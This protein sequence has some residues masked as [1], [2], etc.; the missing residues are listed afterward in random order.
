MVS[1]TSYTYPTETENDNSQFQSQG[2]SQ[3][4]RDSIEGNIKA[5]DAMAQSGLLDNCRTLSKNAS[6]REIFRSLLLYILDSLHIYR[7]DI[8][9]KLVSY[10]HVT[11]ESAN[12]N[13]K[14]WIATTGMDSYIKIEQTG[15]DKFKVTD[16]YRELKGNSLKKE[17]RDRDFSGRN[18]KEFI[19]LLSEHD[20]LEKYQLSNVTVAANAL[21]LEVVNNNSENKRSFGV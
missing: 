9:D 20:V 14:T 15:S 17:S 13:Y 8:S 2:L 18:V 5:F 4:L 1:V 11:P 21:T 10:F 7:H 19:G 6:F 16:V 3:S 12:A